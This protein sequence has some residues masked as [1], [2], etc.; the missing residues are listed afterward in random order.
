[1]RLI[2]KP[3]ESTCLMYTLK[4]SYLQVFSDN[5]MTSL[6]QTDRRRLLA[7]LTKLGDENPDLRAKAALAATVLLHRK[8]LDWSALI[9]TGSGKGDSDGLA[10]D[11]KLQAVE[12]ANHNGLT[13]AER[14]FV[15]KVAGWRA[16]G[17]EGL[18][19][20]RAIAERIDVELR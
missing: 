9:P 12:L 1:M 16:P 5:A 6:R 17:A 3:R 14:N 11:W 13:S 8:G 7:Y 20:L 19:R 10:H 2:L 18:V 4:R 15:M